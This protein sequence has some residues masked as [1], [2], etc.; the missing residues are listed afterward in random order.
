VNQRFA[1]DTHS[2]G[3]SAKLN[4]IRHFRHG[5]GHWILRIGAKV[6]PINVPYQAEN[7]LYP[8]QVKVICIK[9]VKINQKIQL[10]IV[11]CKPLG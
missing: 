6:H 8:V 2:Q 4:L 9:W 10:V 5:F 1:Y 3:L 7:T 11:V